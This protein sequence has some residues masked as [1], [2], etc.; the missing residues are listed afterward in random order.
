MTHAPERAVARVD[1]GALERNC[2][3]LRS[4]LSGQTELCAVVKA[5]AYGHGDVWCAK[6]ALAGG[7]TWLAVASA[8]EAAELRRHGIAARIL[9]MGALTHEEA[10][11]AIEAAAEVVVWDLDFARALANQHPAGA[12]RLP[13]HVKVDSGMG[14]LGTKDL[15]TARSLAELAATDERLELAGLMTHFATADDLGDEHFAAAARPCSSRSRG[16]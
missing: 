5:D 13:V 10:R 15:D 9:T 11:L 8:G 14:R 16:S 1:L 4:L 3:H 6:A 12:A 2:A 7:A